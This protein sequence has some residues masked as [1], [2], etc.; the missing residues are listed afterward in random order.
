[1]LREFPEREAFPVARVDHGEF[2]VFDCIHGLGQQFKIFR[3]PGRGWG[4]QVHHQIPCKQNFPINHP[5]GA[6]GVSR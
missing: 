5:N 3:E 6:H 1:M 2:P 4:K